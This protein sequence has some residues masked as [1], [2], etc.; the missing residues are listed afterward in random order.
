MHSNVNL[1]AKRGPGAETDQAV[2]PL[3]H[4]GHG[5]RAASLLLGATGPVLGHGR[6]EEVAQ[7]RDRPLLPAT[8]PSSRQSAR[9][10]QAR[11][12]VQRAWPPV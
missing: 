2:E 6:H 3:A 7:L 5:A 8:P 10:R 9:E 12:E 11:R 4:L 1:K